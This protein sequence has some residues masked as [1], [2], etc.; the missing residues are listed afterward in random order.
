[1][2]N[3]L[4]H[5]INNKEVIDILDKLI[6]QESKK[7]ACGNMS[8]YILSDIRDAAAEDPKWFFNTFYGRFGYDV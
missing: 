6:E 5:K 1:M 4:R 3:I 7:D 8:L 2:R